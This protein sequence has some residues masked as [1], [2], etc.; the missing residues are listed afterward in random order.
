M[1]RFEDPHRYHTFSPENGQA[2]SLSQV[3]CSRGIGFQPV[4]LFMTRFED[5]YRYHSLCP[6]SGQAGSLSHVPNGGLRGKARFTQ[7]T[8]R[9]TA[10][11]NLPKKKRVA[12]GDALRRIKRVREPKEKGV[13]LSTPLS[14]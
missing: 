12:N 7:T 6:E 2:G 13:S 9:A 14:H 3:V 10:G 4:N 11:E 8:A 5:P 1:T